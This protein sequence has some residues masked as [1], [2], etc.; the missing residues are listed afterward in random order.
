M[1]QFTIR[2][3]QALEALLRVTMKGMVPYMQGPPG[4][5]KSD[6]VRQ[7]AEKGNLKV[8]DI[9]L[10]QAMPEDLNGF[11]MKNAEGTKASF[12]PF[13]VFPIQGDALPVRPDG[14]PYAGWL[15]FL[16]ELSSAPKAVQA[17]AYKL[18]LDRMVGSYHLHDNVVMVAA[19]N[20]MGDKAVV[21]EQSTALRSRLSHLE[22]EYS[23]PD[24]IQ[25]GNTHG[26]DFRVLAYNSWKPQA[27]HDF[28]PQRNDK[29]FACPRTWEFVSRMIKGKPELDGLDQ[30]II[31]G[32]IGDKHGVQFYQFCQ[33]MDKLP[34]LDKILADPEG[35]EV[36]STSDLRYAVL[37]SIQEHATKENFSKL[38][39]Y[40][41]RFPADFQVIFFRGVVQRDIQFRTHPDYAANITRLLRFINEDDRAYAPA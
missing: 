40:V 9:R 17:A 36:P 24:F 21:V 15:I 18:I 8:I 30:I 6:I 26:M 12:I 1:A 22:L 4:I 39:R 5:G 16:D 14:T 23:Q 32:Q 10:S 19:G 7:L 41:I 31:T 3:S 27:G 13:D 34:S 37:T 38:V 11:P 25:Y 28:D 2:P 29:T 20:R 35:A 33:L